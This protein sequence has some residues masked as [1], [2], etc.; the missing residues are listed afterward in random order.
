MRNVE[1]VEPRATFVGLVTIGVEVARG[2]VVKECADRGVLVAEGAIQVTGH[3]EALEA[4]V[5]QIIRVVAPGEVK[6]RAT[7]RIVHVEPVARA[8]EILL[9][10]SLFT[11]VAR[12]LGDAEVV[13]AILDSAGNRA[14]EQTNSDRIEVISRNVS[15]VLPA[16]KT[17][18][19]SDCPNRRLL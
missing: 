5:N 3:K 4:A 14:G 11:H 9:C 2:E 19:T 10:V 15:K 6:K 13:V 1:S 12:H 8:A 17:T 18:A 16:L 7:F